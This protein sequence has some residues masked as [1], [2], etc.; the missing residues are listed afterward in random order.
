LEEACQLARYA[1]MS[2]KLTAFGIT[3]FDWEKLEL[4]TAQSVAQII[5]YFL[6]GFCNRKS[7]YPASTSNLVQ[8]LVH[9]KEQDIHVG[10]WKS[11]KSG[12]W[13]FQI[14]DHQP[15][16]P[17]SYEDYKQASRGELTDRLMNSL[18]R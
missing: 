13:W 5:W 18:G 4:Q 2:D 9:L 16:I 1:G 14:T 11:L 8:Y 7:D 15:L 6:D 3:G 10:F 17:C 12:R